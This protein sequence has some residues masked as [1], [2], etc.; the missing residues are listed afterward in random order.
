MRCTDA[1]ASSLAQPEIA[2]F[3]AADTHRIF[4]HSFKYR[5][6]F[7]RRLA[8]DLQHFGGCSLL[9]QRFAE[10][11]GAL[12]QLVEQPRVLDGDDGLSSEVLDQLDLLVGEGADLLSVDSDSADQFV[13][14]EHRNGQY[15]PGTGELDDLRKGVAGWDIKVMRLVEDVRDLCWLFGCKCA[16]ERRPRWRSEC[17]IVASLVDK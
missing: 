5:L 1:H 8:N 14:L 4:Q 7:A 13:V 6:Q 3:S 9:L 12:S 11:V 10:I 17:R 2:E 16:S 15:C